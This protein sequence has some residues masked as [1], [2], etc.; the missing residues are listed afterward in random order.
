MHIAWNGRMEVT[1][2]SKTLL[3]VG[4]CVCVCVCVCVSMISHNIKYIFN[5]GL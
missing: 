3:P 1:V 2:S 5:K 4:V